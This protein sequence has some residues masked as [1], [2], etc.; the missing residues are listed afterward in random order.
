[1]NL[2]QRG[3]L[4]ELTR[5]FSEGRDQSTAAAGEIEFLLDEEFPDDDEM[6]GYVSDLSRFAPG[7]GEHLHDENQIAKVCRDILRRLEAAQDG[8]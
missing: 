8:E 6:Q 4:R 7:G 5:A 2:Q 1:M 3:R